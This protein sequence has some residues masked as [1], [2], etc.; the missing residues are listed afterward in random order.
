MAGPLHEAV[1][2]QFEMAI[3]EQLLDIKRGNDQVAEF[4][5]QIFLCGGPKV[6]NKGSHMPDAS[7][8]HEKARRFGVIIEVSHSQK[9]KDLP[10]LA[11]DYILGSQ[12]LTQLVIGI[13][14]EYLEKKGKEA[15]VI[16]W[17]PRYLQ[18]D[19]TT[20]LE[21][22]QTDEGGVF[23]AADGSLV[24]GERAIHI[25]LKD[26]GNS[27]DYPGIDNVEG[28]ITISFSQ[29]YDMVRRGEATTQSGKQEDIGPPGLVMRERVRSPPEELHATD[30]KR[31]K[32]AEDE[33][34]EQLYEQDGEYVPEE[35]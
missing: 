23:R 30:E 2:G 7:F 15:K 4:A 19:G 3:L 20:V 25:G 32:E 34:N 33:V 21:A 22:T 26:F 6:T 28:E 13:D 12:G 17:R 35:D 16:I 9:G 31:F 11:D 1:V 14:L 5:R 8:K 24:D 18:E 29:L 27:D 10:Y